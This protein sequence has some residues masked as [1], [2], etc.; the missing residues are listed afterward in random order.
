MR[1]V[2]L[3]LPLLLMT[4]CAQPAVPVPDFDDVLRDDSWEL[5]LPAPRLPDKSSPDETAQS[6][7]QSESPSPRRIER[8][9]AEGELTGT[10]IHCAPDYFIVKRDFR[11]YVFLFVADS[12]VISPSSRGSSELVRLCQRVRVFYTSN[13]N[14]FYADSIRIIDED[15]CRR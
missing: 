12:S 9:S 8:C 11:E 14:A 6:A 7:A 15:V 5:P 4:F 1:A 2:L 13:N 3:L 10:V